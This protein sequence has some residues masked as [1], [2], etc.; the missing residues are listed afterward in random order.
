MRKTK[1]RQDGI[2][3]FLCGV[4]AILVL[5]TAIAMSNPRRTVGEFVPP[6][7]EPAAVSGVPEVPEELGYAELYQDGMAYRVS[8]C[9]EP[10]AGEKN[11]T[12]YFTNTGSNEKYLKLRVLDERGDTLGE[13]GLLRPGEYVQSVALNRSLADGM[14]IRLKVMGYEPEDYT[15]AGAVTL[16]VAV[17]SMT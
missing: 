10:L 9:G 11:L 3:P 12:V 15:S 14:Q 16:S 4:L 8:V 6:E 5:A 17:R 7:F 13:T 2:I 1:K